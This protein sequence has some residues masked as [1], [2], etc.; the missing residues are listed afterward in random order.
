LRVLHCQKSVALTY[1]TGFNTDQHKTKM[2]FSLSN[3]GIENIMN[4]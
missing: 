2:K 1:K 4:F 3:V